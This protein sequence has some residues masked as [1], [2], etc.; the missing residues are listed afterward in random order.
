MDCY[1]WFI[2]FMPKY[3]LYV[4]L[5]SFLLFIRFKNFTKLKRAKG[6]HLQYLKSHFGSQ[7][8]EVGEIY[9][10]ISLKRWSF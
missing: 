3:E 8:G 1:D 2:D 10:N 4:D 5:T 9:F 7:G 6:S